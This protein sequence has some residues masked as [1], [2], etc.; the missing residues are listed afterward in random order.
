MKIEREERKN[1]TEGGLRVKMRQIGR[2]SDRGRGERRKSK[3]ER[4]FCVGRERSMTWTVS[5]GIILVL[6]YLDNP[7][8]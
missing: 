3:Q 1:G 8:V 4:K 7:S 5:P 6:P 2:K